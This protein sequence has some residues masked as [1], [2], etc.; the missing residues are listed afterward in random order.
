MIGI[1][2]FVRIEGAAMCATCGRS[3]D[4]CDVWKEL[5]RKT[6]KR[7]STQEVSMELHPEVKP[8]FRNEVLE[9][10]KQI[11]I[12]RPYFTK[13]EYTTLIATRAQQLAEGAKPLVD[14]KGL[15]TSDPMFLWTVAKMEIAERKLPYIIRRQ[16]PN[17][18]SEFWSVQELESI[19]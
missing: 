9:M 3:C 15:K 10:G 13:Y 16:L 6:D 18:T 14:L 12:T 5:R 17:N 7:S 11:R 1:Y 2:V 8:V 4:V 19:W